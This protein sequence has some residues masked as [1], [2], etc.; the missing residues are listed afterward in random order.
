MGIL[1]K[2][3]DA[4]TYKDLEEL[5]GVSEG[6]LLEFKKALDPKDPWNDLVKEF[7][8]FANT[9]GGHLVLGA[10]AD[11]SGKLV[12]LPG[13]DSVDGFQ[14]KVIDLCLTRVSPAATPYPSPAI[15]IPQSQKV[16]YVVHV[17]SSLAGP[18]FLL[19][20]KGAYLR[21]SEHDK[22]FEPRLAEWE[23]LAF[24]AGRRERALAL[25]SSLKDRASR[26]ASMTMPGNA[27]L[28]EVFI[29]PA[30]PERPLVDFRRLGETAEAAQVQARS[31]RHPRGY[32]WGVHEGI[33]YTP[34][35]D[36]PQEYYVEG[37]VYGTVFADVNIGRKVDGV[38]RYP[39]LQVL[40]N[41]LLWPLYARRFLR[42][43]GYQGPVF[44]SGGLRRI[45]EREFIWSGDKWFSEPLS[46][47]PRF[48]ED[49]VYEIETDTGRLR[50]DLNGVALDLF[51]PLAY[52]CGFEPLLRVHRGDL[53]QRALE[54]LNLSIGDIA[55][56]R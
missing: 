35:A 41:F 42:R 48:D 30:Y 33:V 38:E 2:T 21:V 26:R 47:K 32:A 29:T 15:P 20:R 9:Y 55:A 25:R 31:V 17:P 7:V 18:H 46:Y 4:Y 23:E 27:V 16:L 12:A 43:I 24:L 37:S 53:I 22:P 52:A 8:A 45:R 50:D 49:A 28:A 51:L 34:D 10:E 13:I 6:V 19:G 56:N 11:K 44:L 1:E 3:V 39:L 14:Q 5:I 54:Y 40:V 36:S